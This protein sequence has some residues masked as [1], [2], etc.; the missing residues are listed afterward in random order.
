MEKET[1][2][3]ITKN[4]KNY[5][6]F[7][8]HQYQEIEKKE[9]ERIGDL[10]NNSTSNHIEKDIFNKILGLIK[11]EVF[12]VA[13]PIIFSIFYFTLNI[14][15]KYSMKKKFN[16]PMEYF[17]LDL[18]ETISY[19]FLSVIF[20]TLLISFMYIL[21][22]LTNDI[23]KE[24]V[25]DIIYMV[26]QFILIIVGI[27]YMSLQLFIVEKFVLEKILIFFIIWTIF[28]ISNFL[29]ENELKKGILHFSINCFLFSWIWYG[30]SEYILFIFLGLFLIFFIIFFTNNMWRPK[31]KSYFIFLYSG[32][33]L[34]YIPFHLV[35]VIYIASFVMTE[36]FKYEIFY[37]DNESKVI[38]TTYES[39]Y[40]IMNC[41]INQ[42]EL[43]VY[44]EEYKFLDINEVE[45]IEYK[46]FNDVKCL[47]KKYEINNLIVND[48][49][50]KEKKALFYEPFI[51][52]DTV[53]STKK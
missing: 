11:K 17:K 27:L 28:F 3:I 26:L 39:K 38:I 29:S 12:W 53:I 2:N 1:N 20:M 18:T 44:T 30:Y 7:S 50:L 35:F 13:I 49:L 19:F 48:R 31:I 41:Y 25:K 22:K 46:N 24:I 52:L 34:L 33:Y 15:Y 32:I 21:K 6:N 47:T 14:K 5:N 51:I 4:I 43:T 8:Y 37:K 9:N 16:L 42:K 36:R 45:F 23:R 40:L 10:W